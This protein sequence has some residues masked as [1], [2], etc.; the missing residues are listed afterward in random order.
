MKSH[1]VERR[2]FEYGIELIYF[3]E[4]YVDIRLYSTPSVANFI[5]VVKKGGKRIIKRLNKYY[6]PLRAIEKYLLKIGFEKEKHNATLN[7]YIREERLYVPSRESLI[8]YVRLIKGVI[9]ALC[10]LENKE[11]IDI[12][13]EIWSEFN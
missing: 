8:D 3:D 9:R 1:N 5:R 7:K 2:I 10:V 11:K 13:N 12:I 4:K 6:I